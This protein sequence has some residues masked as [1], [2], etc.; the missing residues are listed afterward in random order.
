MLLQPHDKLV[1]REVICHSEAEGHGDVQIPFRWKKLVQEY[2]RRQ[3]RMSAA[4]SAEV[5]R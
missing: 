2:Y 3:Y 5:R 4:E 1:T